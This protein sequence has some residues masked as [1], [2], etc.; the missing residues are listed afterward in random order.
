M[1]K[2]KQQNRFKNFLIPTIFSAVILFL[3][4]AFFYLLS[5]KTTK[6][7]GTGAIIYS[8]LFALLLFL[9]FVWLQSL[10]VKNKY[11]ALGVSLLLLFALVRSI[12]YKFKGPYTTIF[13]IIG[14]I[15]FLAWMILTFLLTKKN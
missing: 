11:L 2:E 4:I 14:G 8:L 9:I 1:K 15:V 7:F 3:S 12:L 6:T 5:E 10:F 13:L